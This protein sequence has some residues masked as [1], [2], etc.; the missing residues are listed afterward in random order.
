M[1]IASLQKKFSWARE[2]RGQTRGW[3]VK[4]EMP[5]YPSINA[6][7]NSR[8]EQSSSPT[9]PRLHKKLGILPGE[10]VHYFAS[11][12]GDW[13]RALASKTNLRASD[14][15][16]SMAQFV[17]RKGKHIPFRAIAG[18]SVPRRSGVYDWSVSFS[19]Y[20]MVQGAGIELNALRGLM[21]NKGVKIISDNGGSFFPPLI[22]PIA[23]IYGAR[24][25]I[26]KTMS[27][28]PHPKGCG[29]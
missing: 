7:N 12:F 24:L 16:K 1:D 29:F 5:L 23:D 11:Y 26:S 20:P 3:V 25:E 2:K 14:A 18:E 27:E 19:P 21:N 6:I 15:S 9:D 13:A 8:R 17:E 4:K 22:K 28:L 10:R